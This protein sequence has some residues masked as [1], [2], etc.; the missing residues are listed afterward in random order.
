VVAECAEVLRESYWAQ[1]STLSGVL[2]EARRVA[3]LLPDDPDVVEFVE[4][5]RSAVTMKRVG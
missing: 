5:M 4:L 2:E 3:P 1:D